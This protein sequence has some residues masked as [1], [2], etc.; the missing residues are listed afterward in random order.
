M[1][2][3]TYSKPRLE[4]LTKEQAQARVAERAFHEPSEL[5][6]PTCIRCGHRACPLCGD[7]CDVLLDD[8]DDDGG[9][10]CCEGQCTYDH[11][12]EAGR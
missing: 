5:E 8:V 7:W 12:S 1:P 6:L 10:M 9:A 2:K 11:A 4:P 3:K